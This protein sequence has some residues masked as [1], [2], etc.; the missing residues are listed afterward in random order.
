VISEPLIHVGYH[1]TGTTWLQRRIFSDESLGYTQ[2]RPR[3]LIDE[4]FVVGNP[5]RFDPK[6]ATSHF[7]KFA[8]EAEEKGT[9]LVVSHERL[10][11]LPLMNGVDARPIADRIAATYPQG[12]VL[13]VI[14]EQ[15]E[16]MLSIYKQNILRFG[17]DPF[18]HMWRERTIRERRRPGPSLEVYEYHDLIGYYMELFGPERVLVLPFEQLKTDAVGFVGEIQKFLGL[19]LPTEVPT[20]RDNVA[21]PAAAISLVRYVNV[22]FRMLGIGTVFAGP[23][24]DKRSRRVRLA[25]LKGAGPVLPRS[26]SRRIEKR[27]RE[28]ALELATGRF[29]ES[30]RI[31][32]ELTGLDLSRYGY[33]LP[34][35][36]VSKARV[37]QGER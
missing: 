28:T 30:N 37:D 3:T 31:T 17:K 21:L 4:A 8:A 33:D 19:P 20:D 11:G 6:E 22:F 2:I 36:Y 29:A 34:A 12:K 14:R 5:W 10:S 24:A 26:W 1:K 18:E 27:W 25:I 13:I 16:M 9:T 35:N 7:E 32:S 23:I 15:R